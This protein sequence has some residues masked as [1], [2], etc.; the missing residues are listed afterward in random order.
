MK[1]PYPL[2]KPDGATI[3]DDGQD[4]VNLRTY[5]LMV[6]ERKWYAL[7]VFMATMIAVV[8]YTLVSTPIYQ[9]VATVEILKH[10]AQIMRVADI[11]ESSVTSDADFNTQIGILESR[12]IVENV[13]KQ[14]SPE[15]LNQLTAPYQKQD[16]SPAA[17]ILGG[18]FVAPQRSS[19]I[20]SVVFRHPNPKIAA[21]IAN[22]IAREFITYSSKVRVDETMK[23]VVD[24]KDRAEQQRHH[25]E[26]LANSMASYRQRGNLVSLVQSKDIVTEKLKMLNLQATESGTKLKVAEVRWN[27]VQEWLKAGKDISEL[28]FIASQSNIGSLVQQITMQNLALANL[29]QTF[30]PKHPRMIEALNTL[31]EAQRQLQVSLGSAAASI[32]AEYETALQTDAAAR[33]SLADQQTESLEMDKLAVAYENMNREFRVNEQLL[34]AMMSR[35]RETSVT[36][37]IDTQNARII[38]AAMESST[39]ISPNIKANIG[40]GLI[41]GLVL[42]FGCAYLLSILADQV[43]TA[44]DVETLIGLPLIGVVPRTERMEPADKAQIVSNG[45]DPMIVEAFLSLYSSLRLAPE[46][47]DA[48]RILVT[49][50]M[51]GEGKSFIATNLALAFAAQGQRTA[52]VDCD[53]RK[54][55]I[56]QSFRLRASKGVISY[57]NRGVAFDEIVVK[58]VHPNLDVITSGGRSKNPIQ[59]FNT[60]EFETLVEELSRRYDKVIFDTPPL[61]AVSDALNILHLMDGAIYTIRYNRVMRRTARRCARRLSSTDTPVFGAVMNDMDNRNSEE[62]YVQY[63]NKLV[64]EYYNPA[65]ESTA[66]A[67]RVEA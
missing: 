17:V 39:P 38:D 16:L 20:T 10:G 31:D 58:N 11:V 59:L 60:P 23:A 42:A 36:S 29:S 22:L 19:L 34:E 6:L 51:P 21:R 3:A 35:M 25:V 33:K 30:K 32:K 15:E 28:S 66:V 48:R 56:Q 54:P 44:F 46:S 47:R 18:R 27:Q 43:K 63:H 61:G 13:V 9:S 1:P 55:N 45:A 49:S 64:K 37:S 26:E 2:P 50:T 8:T 62:Y 52:I 5:W 41:A 24:L 7:A 57:C 4:E 53:L 12:A 14:L 40:I 65:V 67:S